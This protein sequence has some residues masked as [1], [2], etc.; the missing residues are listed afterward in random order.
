MIDYVENTMESTKKPTE[1]LQKQ[2]RVQKS[3]VFLYTNND[4]LEIVNF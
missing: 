1:R 3:V 2:S 4:Q